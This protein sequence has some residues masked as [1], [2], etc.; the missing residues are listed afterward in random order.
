MTMLIKPRGTEAPAKPKS[1]F[2]AANDWEASRIQSIELSERRAWKVAIGAVIVAVLSWLA[3][4][5]L[6]PLKETVPYIYRTDTKTGVPDLI[7]AM[8]DK[9]ITGDEVMDK[10]WLA[11]YVRARETYDWYTLQGDYDMVGL[12]SS[13]P[14]GAAYAQLFDGKDALDKKY[15]KSVRATVQIVS[16]V[17]DVRNHTGTV[18]F[19]KTTKR[20]DQEGPET[21]SRWVATIAYEYRSTAR[22]KESARLVNPFGFQVLSYR[23][24]PELVGGAQ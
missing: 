5:L 12:L 23:V 18:R 9:A 15:G 4:V 17:P 13:A 6:L 3:I 14:V 7:T 10:Y 16:V 19:I 20:I 11:Q 8:T 1:V 2:D 21:V 22:I 24:D